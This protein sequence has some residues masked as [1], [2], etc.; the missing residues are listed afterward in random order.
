M[1]STKKKGNEDKEKTEYKNQNYY[2]DT[3]HIISP[4]E[5]TA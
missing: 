4:F 5:I 2:E 1:R 3:V